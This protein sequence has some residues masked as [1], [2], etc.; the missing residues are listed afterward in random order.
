MHLDAELD[1]R[2]EK[3]EQDVHAQEKD[4]EVTLF[5]PV[6]RLSS[7]CRSGCVVRTRQRWSEMRNVQ[8]FTGG[9]VFLID[10]RI[11]QL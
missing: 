7:S 9:L 3:H 1:R 8:R 4:G 6:A 2:V 10:F 5:R 11:A